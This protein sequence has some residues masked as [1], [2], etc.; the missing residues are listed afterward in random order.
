MSFMAKLVWV[1]S[2]YD[3]RGV[4]IDNLAYGGLFNFLY[5]NNLVLSRFG[6][7]P[8][9][10]GKKGSFFFNLPLPNGN[11]DW[12]SRYMAGTNRGWSVGGTSAWNHN[13]P[14]K[15]DLEETVYLTMVFDGEGGKEYL[16]INGEDAAEVSIDKS[17]WDGFIGDVDSVEVNSILLGAGNMGSA[18]SWHLTK[19]DCRAVRLY[20]KALTPKE[21]SENYLST[22]SY[23]GFLE[24]IYD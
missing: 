5:G 20:S 18:Y 12:Y 23:H 24:N 22:V 2:H 3:S 17:Y 13:V 11:G 14:T 6:Y 9:G 7:V 10:S 19:M 15:F 4:T 8:D 21:V 16:Y 1:G